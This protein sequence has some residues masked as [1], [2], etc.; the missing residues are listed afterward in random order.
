MP[1]TPER[2]MHVSC[3]AP[4]CCVLHRCNLT[5]TFLCNF[6][7]HFN[8]D[9]IHQK[10][11]Q[12]GKVCDIS[13][14]CT[15]AAPE[16]HCK[17]SISCICQLCLA[18]GALVFLF[19]AIGLRIVFICFFLFLLLPFDLTYVK[20]FSMFLMT[21]THTQNCYEKAIQNECKS[22]RVVLVCSAAPI[23]WYMCACTVCLPCT[24]IYIILLPHAPKYT[25]GTRAHT[26]SDRRRCK[27]E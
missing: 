18:A 9:R 17:Q 26:Q 7:E 27:G 2:A 24:Y 16:W 12:C 4:H 5:A 10:W 3:T 8:E 13:S 25:H 6:P 20:L 14:L 1:K 15:S 11:E 22:I 19:K 21:Y 23:Q